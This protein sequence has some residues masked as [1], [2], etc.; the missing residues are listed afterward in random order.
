[1]SLDCVTCPVREHAACAALTEDERAALARAGR[2]RVLKRGEP[3]FAAGEDNDACATLIEGALKVSSTDEDGTEHILA[4]IHPAGFV[5]ELFQPFAHHDVV[6][7]T[8]SRVCVFARSEME[9]A[10]R[11]YPALAQALLRR[12]QAD[13]YESRKLLA[14]SGRRGATEKV[15]ALVLELAQAASQSSCHPAPEFELPLTRGELAA[16]LGLTIE[17]VSRSLTAIEEEGLIQRKGARGIELVDPA[18]LADLALA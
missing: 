10:L 1:M 6:A 11:R 14:L 9:D 15:A 13:L 12:S 18:R 8:Q 3:L 2:T 4:L 5:G 17:T 16:L 7:L